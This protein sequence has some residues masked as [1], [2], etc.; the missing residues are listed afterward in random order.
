[1]K[2]SALLVIA[3][4]LASCSKSQ[5]EAE[6]AAVLDS[7]TI[8]KKHE[9]AILIEKG[10]TPQF[11]GDL[12]NYWGE[13]TTKLDFKHT[14]KNGRIVKSVFYYQNGNVEEEYTYECTALHGLQ[15]WYFPN[16]QLAQA[17]HYSYG[18]RQGNGVRYDSTGRM[19]ETRVFNAD[20]LVVISD[21]K[22]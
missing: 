4:L 8:A 22:E 12:N 13:D 5:Q 9:Q 17:I 20:T 14:F 15:K 16:G 18:Y 2:S 1:M 6:A 19:L 10:V 21:I 7:C 3:I 11:S